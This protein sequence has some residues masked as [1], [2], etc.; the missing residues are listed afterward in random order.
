MPSSIC[1][2]IS[3]TSVRQR[4][5][6]AFAM[7]SVRRKRFLGVLA[8]GAPAPDPPK[9]EATCPRTRALSV[10]VKARPER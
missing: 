8:A 3:S 1:T 9:A 5:Y 6:E 10:P 4:Q 2:S 7:E